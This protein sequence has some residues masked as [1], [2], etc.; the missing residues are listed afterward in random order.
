MDG[1]GTSTD[2]Y[3]ITTVDELYSMNTTGGN[4]VY[5]KL[6][7]D[8]DL[9]GTQYADNFQV[10]QLKC[11]SLDGDGHKI[12]NIIHN[13]ATS[14]VS[15]FNVMNTTEIKN[16]V[17]ENIRLSGKE[18]TF[19]TSA[20]STS[21]T[22]SLDRCVFAVKAEYN[23]FGTVASGSKRC[24]MHREYLKLNCNLCTFSIDASFTVPY[25]VISDSTINRCQFNLNV[26]YIT[27]NTN[28]SELYSCVSYCNVSESYFVG[29]IEGKYSSSSNYNFAGISSSSNST[30]S[31]SYIAFDI[32]GIADFYFSSSFTSICFYDITRA[33]NATVKNGVSATAGRLLGLTTEQCK[34]AE[35]LRSV[36]FECE[37]G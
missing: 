19:F 8:I 25:S 16:T 1:T 28:V 2:P 15:V 34:N 20:D 7:R 33:G 32:T 22:V 36:G 23:Y 18:V 11:A 13:N 31:A 4:N 12:R 26:S 6:G 3:V 10:I 29:K 30:F 37:E 5:F 35:Y 9:N 24:L 21:R 17:F 14:T 27:P